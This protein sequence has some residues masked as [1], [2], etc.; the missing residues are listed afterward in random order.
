G[1]LELM[2]T[3]AGVSL[4]ARAAA[5]AP[6]PSPAPAVEQVVR[7]AALEAD[8]PSVPEADRALHSR[9][10]RF[11]RVQVAEMRLYKA[12]AVRAGRAQG[13]LY[14]A[15]KSEIDAARE[16]YRTS[17]LAPCASMAD[18][19]HRE[20]VRTLANDDASLLGSAYPGALA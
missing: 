13:D 8:W 16:S 2:T 17:F 9:A 3:L 4:E 7:I 10:Q 14:S 20:L 15:L 5:A 1:S 11:A 18:Y 6:P 12:Q 19:L